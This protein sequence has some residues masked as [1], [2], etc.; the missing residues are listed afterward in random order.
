VEDLMHSVA[1]LTGGKAYRLSPEFGFADIL[2]DV[3]DLGTQVQGDLVV[4]RHDWAIVAVGAPLESM[5]VEPSGSVGPRTMALDDRLEAAS[6]I[7]ARVI[8]ARGSRTTVLRRPG[9]RELVDRFWQGRWRLGSPDE[10]SRP[11]VRLYR[12]PDYLCNWR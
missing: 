12:I 9:T 1:V 5:V 6:G 2:M 4:S 11:A 3:F 8:S 7:R 10:K